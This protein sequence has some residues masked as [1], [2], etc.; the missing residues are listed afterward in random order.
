MPYVGSSG[1]PGSNPRSA[2]GQ[3]RQPPGG[4]GYG[5]GGPRSPVAQRYGEKGPAPQQGGARQVPLRVEKVS[6]RSLQARLIYGNR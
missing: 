4:D 6:D 3:G 5:P 1:L 2:M